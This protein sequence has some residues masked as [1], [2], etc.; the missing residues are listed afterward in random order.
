MCYSTLPDTGELVCIR[1]GES[2]Y[3]PS[4]E[5]TDI[6]D[7]NRFLSRR[8][9]LALGVTNAQRR[10]MEAG[11]VSGWDSPAADP[12]FYEAQE[13]DGARKSP[14]VRRKTTAR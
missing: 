4:K 3:V 13:K 7:Y 10:A 6:A 11:S 2:G 9:N 8:H 1:R 14:G 12:K 5:S